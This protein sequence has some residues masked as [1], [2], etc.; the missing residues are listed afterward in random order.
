MTRSMA[1]RM[2]DDEDHRL[3]MCGLTFDARLDLELEDFEVR[4]HD[5]QIFASGRRDP[6]PHDA[7]RGQGAWEGSGPHRSSRALAPPPTSIR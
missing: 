5:F 3:A 6:A 2:Q 4:A 1:Q 7:K